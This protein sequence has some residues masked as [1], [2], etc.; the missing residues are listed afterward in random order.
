MRDLICH[1]DFPQYSG[2]IHNNKRFSRI[3]TKN[4][5]KERSLWDLTLLSTTPGGPVWL[6]LQKPIIERLQI[7]CLSQSITY[8]VHFIACL[9]PTQSVKSVN[10]GR[11]PAIR[12]SL[13]VQAQFCTIKSETEM[14]NKWIKYAWVYTHLNI[15]L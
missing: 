3:I 5:N 10:E 13:Q 7:Q 9:T 1:V 4:N 11:I 14:E 6:M 2:C 15:V 12:P 8:Q